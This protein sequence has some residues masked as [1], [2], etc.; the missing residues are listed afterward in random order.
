MHEHRQI[1]LYQDCQAAIINTN[2]CHSY[3]PHEL[4]VD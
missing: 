2:F 4:K 3:L 1:L